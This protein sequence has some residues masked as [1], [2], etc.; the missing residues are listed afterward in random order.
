MRD[1]DKRLSEALKEVRDVLKKYD[2]MACVHL[3][4]GEGRCVSG[5]FLSLP[6]WSKDFP[7]IDETNAPLSKNMGMTIDGVWCLSDSIEKTMTILNALKGEVSEYFDVEVEEHVDKRKQL[8][9]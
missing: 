6:T 5:D 4:N 1:E 3:A 7:I 2:L 8:D 9:V